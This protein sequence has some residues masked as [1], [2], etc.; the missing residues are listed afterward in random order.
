MVLAIVV[1]IIFYLIGIINCAH[2]SPPSNVKTR[3]A[4]PVLAMKGGT[5]FKKNCPTVAGAGSHSH[6]LYCPIVA[7]VGSHSHSLYCL[8]AEVGSRYR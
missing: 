4:I 3:D 6:S 8:V 1:Y 5:L 7:E 2:F